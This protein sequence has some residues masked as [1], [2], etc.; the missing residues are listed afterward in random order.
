MDSLPFTVGSV[1]GLMTGFARSDVSPFVLA[2][3]GFSYP[4][5][6]RAKRALDIL[7]SLCFCI[8][9]AP[10]LLVTAL[11]IKMLDGGP[12]LFGH[13]RVGFDRRQFRCWKFRTMVPRAG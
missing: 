13:Q 2:G 10:L 7:L 12:V 5:G 11:A 8:L 6:G 4:L 9:F 3:P 1:L